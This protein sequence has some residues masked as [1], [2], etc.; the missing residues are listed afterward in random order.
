MKQ[1]MKDTFHT[2]G[3]VLKYNLMSTVQEDS[4]LHASQ[5]HML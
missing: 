3:F 5:T 1:K 4:F 2:V